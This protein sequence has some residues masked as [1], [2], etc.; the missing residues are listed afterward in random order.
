M[1]HARPSI[2][3][4]VKHTLATI[5][6]NMAAVT[7]RTPFRHLFR[8]STFVG[9]HPGQVVYGVTI[10]HTHPVRE[11]QPYTLVSD[12]PRACS[13]LQVGK[14]PAIRLESGVDTPFYH[15]AYPQV[16][17]MRRFA[18]CFTDGQGEM[19]VPEAATS[20]AGQHKPLEAY[21][22]REWRRLLAQP[23]H[24]GARVGQDVECVQ[25]RTTPGKVVYGRCLNRLADG[26]FAIGVGG[27]VAHSPSTNVPVRMDRRILQAF[28]VGF[29]LLLSGV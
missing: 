19:V 8:T 1:P 26:G 10:K 27:F 16:A 29:L 2:Y 22:K 13:D 6:H 23:T 3:H 11:N 21:T 12:A 24:P 20:E 15:A 14:K 25:L 9:L 18:E 4:P 28:E 17:R 5:N 7:T